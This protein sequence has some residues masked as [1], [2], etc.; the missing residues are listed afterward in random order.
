MALKL[1]MSETKPYPIV[2]MPILKEKIWG[3]D[4]LGR[5]G[6]KIADGDTIGESWE[7]ADLDSTDPS[8]GGGE[9]ARSVIANGPLAGK[10]I[11]DAMEL[12]SDGMLGQVE[13]SS[14][15]GFPLLVKYLDAR[16]NLSIQVHPSKAYAADHAGA[17][18]KNESWYILHAGPG[19]VIYAGLKPGVTREQLQMAIINGTV[20][21]VMQTH[22][23]IAGECFTLASGTVH[24][25][26]AGV[27]VA[28]VQTPSDTTFRVYDWAREYGRQGRQLHIEQAL[29][30]VLLDDVAAPVAADLGL[31]AHGDPMGGPPKMGAAVTQV[32][33]TDSYTMEIV[34]ASCHSHPLGGDGDLPLVVMVP[35]TMGASVASDSDA[36]EEVMV[37]AG[38][39][40]VVP[41]ACAKDAVLRAGPGTEAVVA[42]VIVEGK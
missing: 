5:F 34:S 37:E 4:A 25:L 35:R 17:H 3:G 32:A 9:A 27:V 13:A 28:E 29:A 15:G 24:A 2:L 41:A 14:E 20:P 42:R 40:I 7:V 39:T 6:K 8:G 33:S 18:V 36:F 12:W 16:E 1:G 10:T 22:P 31:S 11:G 23:A 21:A 38:Q 19:A 26:G 30:C